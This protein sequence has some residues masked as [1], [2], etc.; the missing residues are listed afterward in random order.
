MIGNVILFILALIC[1]AFVKITFVRLFLFLWVFGTLYEVILW[2]FPDYIVIQ[3][4]IPSQRTNIE[5]KMINGFV[6]K[7]ERL[8]Y[9]LWKFVACL[10]DWQ[11][12]LGC[13]ILSGLFIIGIKIFN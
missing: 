4:R 2:Q 6:T 13:L 3:K 7:K 8:Q 9:F 12:I 10:F 1:S 11:A 5:H